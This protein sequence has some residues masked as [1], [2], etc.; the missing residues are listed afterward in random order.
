M[1]CYPLPLGGG[2]HYQSFGF[3]NYEV[4]SREARHFFINLFVTLNIICNCWFWLLPHRNFCVQ[5]YCNSATMGI[6]GSL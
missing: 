1:K 4:L 5:N 2:F 3:V 6:T